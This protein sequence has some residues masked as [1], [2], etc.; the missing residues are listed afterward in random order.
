MYLDA[1]WYNFWRAS[2]SILQITSCIG[3]TFQYSIAFMSMTKYVL[4]GHVP[5]HTNFQQISNKYIASFDTKNSCWEIKSVVLVLCCLDQAFAQLWGHTR[6]T[7]KI[8]WM[9][10]NINKNPTTLVQ[11]LVLHIPEVET[12]MLGRQLF[13]DIHFIMKHVWR[14]TM[15]FA[16]RQSV[17]C[18]V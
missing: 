13:V 3:L 10:W 15:Y 5:W 7:H 14:T 8:I 12:K 2:L 16:M 17:N 1:W 4:N 11:I 6:D 9:A 18:I